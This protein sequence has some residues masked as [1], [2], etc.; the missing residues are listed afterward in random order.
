LISA[1][2]SSHVPRDSLPSIKAS[3][4]SSQAVN[5]LPTFILKSTTSDAAERG[6]LTV[7]FSNLDYRADFAMAS[8]FDPSALGIYDLS[9]HDTVTKGLVCNSIVCIVVVA[10][11]TTLR[12]YVRHFIKHAAGPDDCESNLPVPLPIPTLPSS[13][14]MPNERSGLIPNQSLDFAAAAA[15]SAIV[16]STCCLFAAAQGLGK[17]IWDLAIDSQSPSSAHASLLRISIPLYICYLSYLAANTFIKCSII[18]SYYRL[19]PSQMFRRILMLL[20]C[21]VV[22]TCCSSV[23]VIIFECYPVKSSWD[24]FSPRENCIDIL[25]FFVV[26]SMI[27]TISDII[28]WCCPFP[29]FFRLQMKPRR[30]FQLVLL[31]SAGALYVPLALYWL[32]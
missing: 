15:A 9:E 3:Y 32:Y 29:Q 25:R 27:S 12:I 28:L 17:H 22:L 8:Y 13:D 14:P 10:L 24:W 1:T 23:L 26:T 18:A 30:K 11:V 6:R 19:F 7:S 4:R 21:L 16:L 5:L 20:G 2:P 31:F